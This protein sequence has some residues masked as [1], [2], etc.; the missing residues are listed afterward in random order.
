MM[1]IRSDDRT[2]IKSFDNKSPLC[3]KWL[4]P[5]KS[6]TKVLLPAA[7]L[8]LL[9]YSWQD[10]EFEYDNLTDEEKSIISEEDFDLVVRS[11]IAAGIIE[12]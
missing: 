7:V 1:R 12:V 6:S 4:M 11:L 3:D 9:A 5:I 8:H 2:L 10:A